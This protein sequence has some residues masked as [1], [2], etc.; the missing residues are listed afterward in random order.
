[1]PRRR[2]RSDPPPSL[3]A[4]DP[5]VPTLDLHGHTGDEALRRG[6]SWLREQQLAG[7]RRVRLVTGRGLRS[8]GPPVLRGEI[9]GLL[10]RLGSGPV[11]RFETE[12][13][14]GAFLVHL[15]APPSAA[16]PP[17]VPSVRGIG[18]LLPELRGRAETALEE[19]GVKPTPELIDA[20]IRRLLR[21][22]GDQSG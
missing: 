19:L 13:A 20:E 1:M 21:E 15:R 14:G 22:E 16:K 10:Q 3:A 2:K 12:A 8:V 17:P 4:G 6:E 5:A 9:E 18:R 11:E 7:V